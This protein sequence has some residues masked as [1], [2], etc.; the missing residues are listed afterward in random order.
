VAR[1]AG[2]ADWTHFDGGPD[3]NAVSA[4]AEATGLHGL[5]WIDNVREVRWQKTGPHGGDQ[6]NMRILGRV[7]PQAHRIEASNGGNTWAYVADA[8]IGL[9]FAIVG[10]RVVIGTHDG[11]VHG[12]DLKTGGLKWRYFVAPAHR[13]I[14]AN[15]MLTS[16]WPVFGV[17]D[18]GCGQ[19]V[20]SAGTHVEMDG[21]VRVVALQANDGALVWAKTITKTAS[22]IPPGGK[23]SQIVEHSL[24]NAAPSVVGGKVIIDGGAHLGRLEFDPAEPEASI[25]KRLSE[26]PPAK[27][28]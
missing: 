5:Q 23:G 16:A 2:F 1:P 7:D 12:L 26:K 4:D 18:L 22:K 27:K 21:G 19:V 10:D 28:R 17:T 15:G 20:A 3:G 25:T 24:I 8:R 13:L 14:I 11:W 6:G 9:D